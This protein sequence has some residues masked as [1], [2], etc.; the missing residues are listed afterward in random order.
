MKKII[1]SEC[2]HG[3]FPLFSLLAYAFVLPLIHLLNFFFL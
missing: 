3:S 2:Q 1:L